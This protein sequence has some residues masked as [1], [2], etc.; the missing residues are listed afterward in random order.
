VLSVAFTS[1]ATRQWPQDLALNALPLVHANH[2]SAPALVF[3]RETTLGTKTV[4]IG[5]GGYVTGI[6][7]HPREQDLV[8]IKTDVGG[9]YRWNINQF[10]WEPLTD[11]FPLAQSNYYGGESLALDPQD[12]SVVYIAAGKYTADWSKELGSI[13]KSTDRGKT[14][15]KLNLDLKMGGNEDLRWVG[16]RLAVNPGNSQ[17]ILFGSRLDGLWKSADAGITWKQMSFPGKS[18]AGIGI[19]SVI[20]DP[21]TANLVYAIAYSDG[22][23]QSKDGGLTWKKLVGSPSLAKRM[24]L[25]SNGVLYVTHAAGV[26]RYE[27]D[28]WRDITPFGVEGSFNAISIAPQ[29]AQHVLVS[30]GETDKTR[31]FL[32][33]DG[34]FNWTEKQRSVNNT[35]PWWSD[36]MQSQPWVSAIAFDP[37]HPKKVWLTDWYGIWQTENIYTNPGLWTNYQQGHEELVT[38]SLLA[39]PKGALLLSGVADVDGF[40]H[41]NGLDAAP[42]QSF[43]RSRPTLQVPSLR[44]RSPA[45]QDTY[46]I[47][48]YQQ[49]PLKL[50]RVGGNRFNST[51]NGATSSDGGETWRIFAD[52]P[53]D[54]L[55]MRVAI[56]ATDPDRFIVTVSGGPPL[57]TTNNGQSWRKV[58][59]LPDGVQGPWNWAQSLAA[60][61]VNGNTFYYYADG[62]V[63][64]SSNGGIS[65]ES[66]NDQLPNAAWHALKTVPD[67]PGEVW[68]SL[69]RQGLYH[70]R[71]G[72]RTFAQLPQVQ[73]AYLFAF[74]LPQ[75][76]SS[77]PTLY[78]YGNIAGMG[79][80]IFHSGDRGNTWTRLGNTANPIGND[81]N[82]MEA[83]WQEFGLVFVGTNGR[84]IYYGSK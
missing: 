9:F 29:A 15:K 36:Y 62:I 25:S 65:F 22:I 83:S 63:Y 37:H 82:V 73:R 20:F 54:T 81:P 32:S 23:Y 11:R 7:L 44:Y 40:Y 84:G 13:F 38:F 59:G 34:G 52:F 43:S 17:E 30:L 26:S 45:F 72:G 56:S 47:A 46:S 1:C 64:R 48:Y 35:V 8:Y 6:Y 14:W 70:S 53:R 2:Q 31:L 79:E 49:D 77:T 68:L 51:Y 66:I 55:P 50:V 80:G 60:D 78:L 27:K 58:S 71:N 75:P 4:T 39:P 69:D 24:A 10:R 19:T 12:P 5:G 21:K 57:L 74:G 41:D 18:Q 76:G 33:L 42:S 61:P 3:S 16:E 67:N 28:R